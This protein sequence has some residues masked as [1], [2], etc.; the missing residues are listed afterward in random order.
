[1]GRTTARRAII[2]VAVGVVVAMSR[3]TAGAQAD[4]ALERCA[5]RSAVPAQLR[6]LDCGLATAIAAGLER[7]ATFRQEVERVGTLN[8][9]VFIQPRPSV[10]FRTN[11]T[12]D[13]ALSHSVTVA[14]AHRVLRLLVGVKQGDAPIFVLAHE[15]QHAIE[16][17]GAADVSTEDAVDQLFERIGV[18]TGAGVVETQAAVDTERAVRRELLQR[19]ASKVPAAVSPAP[20]SPSRSR[21]L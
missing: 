11:R 13:G 9:I 3:G 7:S 18:H 5:A 2:G 19:P 4:P 6:P 15:L 21:P 16:V 8:G 1:V 12:L 10:N 20:T 14:G 17:L